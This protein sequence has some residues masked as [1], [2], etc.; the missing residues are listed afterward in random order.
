MQY[1][2]SAT[3]TTWLPCNKLALHLRKADM[4][5]KPMIPT[6][7]PSPIP[8]KYLWGDEVPNAIGNKEK[9]KEKA[10]EALNKKP[11]IKSGIYGYIEFWEKEMAK[12][13]GFCR[14]FPPYLE[15]W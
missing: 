11:V 13:K 2:E 9:A 6:G 10:S 3:S 12:Y 1:K 15:Y 8:F 5:G 4:D 14:D 7:N